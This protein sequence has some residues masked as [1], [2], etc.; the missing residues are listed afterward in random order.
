MTY[1]I[2][3]EALGHRIKSVCKARGM[4]AA[5][6]ASRY[7]AD[8]IVAHWHAAFGPLPMMVK[9]GLLFDQAMRPTIDADIHTPRKFTEKEV[10]DG[11]RTLVPVLA[12]EGIAIQRVDYAE[13]VNVDLP[14][15]VSRYQ[16]I[17]TAGGIRGGTYLDISVGTGPDAFPKRA[18][19]TEIPS[20]LPRTPGT[21]MRAQPLEAAA[22]DKLLAV[23]RQEP[24]DF[25]MK[26]AADLL[27]FDQ[28]G[29]DWDR[30]ARELMRTCRY[31]GIDLSRLEAAPAGLSWSHLSQR[32]EAWDK[33]CIERN[34]TE[35]TLDQA[36]IDLNGVFQETM[37]RVRACVLADRRQTTRGNPDMRFVPPARDMGDNVIA[38]RP[39]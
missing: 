7:V 31:R 12:R 36:H 27:S 21:P 5:K 17:A 6:A 33:L 16:V 2:S 4:D 34:I 30:V 25:R 1:E 8:R 3:A 13:L 32:S 20:F 26:H 9:G 15:P 10:H 35:M 14:D 23:I 28:M 24:G 29:L 38:F 39:R 37:A 18:F 22:A 19:R 11:L